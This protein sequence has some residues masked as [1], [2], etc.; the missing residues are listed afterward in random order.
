MND[1]Y[2]HEAFSWDG[3][4]R[5][6]YVHDVDMADWQRLWDYL[7][8]GPYALEF[9]AD[10]ERHPLP[11]RVDAAFDQAVEA[12]VALL[13]DGP[14][15]ALVCH[16]F[17]PNE[18]ELDVDPRAID[19]EQRLDRLLTFLRTLARLLRKEVILTP[20]NLPDHPW[21]RIDPGGGAEEWLDDDPAPD[22]VART[23]RESRERG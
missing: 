6:I 2:H 23:R 16:F 9:T 11:D 5:D 21:F 15:L 18:I 3:S 19:G 13:I 4:L 10:G 17:T 22:D 12:S 1:S 8:A 20:E 7:R 14:H